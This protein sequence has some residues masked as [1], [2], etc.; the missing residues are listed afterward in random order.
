MDDMSKTII[1]GHRVSLGSKAHQL[2]LD[3]IHLGVALLPN[4][5][6]EVTYQVN[7][8]HLWENEGG[9]SCEGSG[10]TLEAAIAVCIAAHQAANKTKSDF[11]VA[12]SATLTV[13]HGTWKRSLAISPDLYRALV[14]SGLFEAPHRRQNTPLILTNPRV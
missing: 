1:A 6:Y 12:W 2:Y 9:I 10:E 7:T 13:S 11:Q 8:R 5:K 4:R 3:F 14:P